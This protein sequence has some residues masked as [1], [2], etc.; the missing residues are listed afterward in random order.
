MKKLTANFKSDMI[1]GFVVFLVAVPLCLGI[2]MASGAPLFSGMIAGIIGGLVVGGISKSPLS[3]SGPAAGLTAIVLS[4][5]TTL[6]SFEGFLVAVIIS[7]IIQFILGLVKAGTIG[8]YVPSNVVTGM[9]TAI[10]VIIIMGQLPKMLGVNMEALTDSFTSSSMSLDKI[11]HPGVLITGTICLVLMILWDSYKPEKV[12]LIPGAL[13]AVISGVIINWLFITVG[14]QNLIINGEYLVSLPVAES[15]SG[16]L[17]QFA[18]PDFSFISNKDVWIIGITLAVVASLETL[19]TIEATDKIDPKK[20]FTDSNRELI[21]QGTGNMLSGFVGGIPITSVIVRSSANL[22]A[23]AQ[24][25]LSTMI[26]GGL[27]FIGALFIPAIL[28]YIPIASLASILVITGYK[29]CKPTIF[30]NMFSKSKY[31]WVPFIVTVIAIIATD[32]L[33]GVA[34]G[35]VFAVGAIL[36]GNMKN[37]YYLHNTLITNKELLRI[38]LAQEVSFLNKATLAITLDKLPDNSTVVID[39]KNTYYI[40]YDILEMIREFKEFNAPDRKIKVVLTGFKSE[41]Q[42]DNNDF[43]YVHEIPGLNNHMET[44]NNTNKVKSRDVL[45]KLKNELSIT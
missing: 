44:V 25:K 15:F 19:L 36:I 30:K 45:R 18:T 38:E 39:A 40:D 10:G 21:A 2:A 13:I 12:K 3:V 9:L 42:I 41:Y 43:E 20:R 17:S 33:M 6:G 16:F 7:G 5:I 24:S 11:L 1:S 8:Y 14:A 29:L 31:Q 37:S 22:N 26:H 35:M 34:I 4:G 23:G 32:L 27:L 28:N